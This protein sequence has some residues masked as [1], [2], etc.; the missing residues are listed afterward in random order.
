MTELKKCMCDVSADAG[1]PGS[2]DV[3]FSEGIVKAAFAVEASCA[4]A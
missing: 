1:A 4:R 3:P 2:E